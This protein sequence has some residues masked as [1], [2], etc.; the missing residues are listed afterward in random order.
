MRTEHLLPAHLIQN[1]RPL[2]VLVVGAG[3]TGSASVMGLPYLHQALLAW[4]RP[5]GLEVILGDRDTVSATNCVRQ[6]FSERDIAQ[7]IALV[8]VIRI[9]Q[10]W[11]SRWHAAAVEITPCRSQFH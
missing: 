10:F 7:N 2:R 4:G 11:G 5:G 6:P 3:G 9:N 1:N 8:L